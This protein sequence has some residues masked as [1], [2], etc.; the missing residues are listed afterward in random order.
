[1]SVFV[2]TWN[3]NREGAGYDRKRAALMA[4]FD[5]YD[6][7]GDRGLESVRF[8]S[9]AQTVQQLGDQLRSRLDGNDRLFVS[10]LHR[11]CHWGSLTPEVWT[12]LAERL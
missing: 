12:W 1:M 7:I 8:V 6:C 5:A 9:S 2:V 3:L 4:A 10:R 11:G